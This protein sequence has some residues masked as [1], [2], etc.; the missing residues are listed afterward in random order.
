MWTCQRKP[1]WGGMTRNSSRFPSSLLSPSSWRK[2]RAR[3]SFMFSHVAFQ[4]IT[5]D[6]CPEPSDRSCHASV[7]LVCQRLLGV[8]LLRELFQSVGR[9]AIG[10][11]MKTARGKEKSVLHFQS[12]ECACWTVFLNPAQVYQQRTEAFNVVL[13]PNHDS[14]SEQTPDKGVEGL[15]GNGH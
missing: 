1:G 15:H 11:L 5:S 6:K 8:E 13:Q 14:S 2:R 10:I 12:G 3:F 4:I 9:H 7:H